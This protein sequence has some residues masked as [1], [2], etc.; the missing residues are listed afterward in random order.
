MI[1]TPGGNLGSALA[2]TPDGKYLATY[3]DSQTVSVSILFYKWSSTFWKLQSS[4]KAVTNVIGSIAHVAISNDGIYAAYT[5]GTNSI[6]VYKRNGNSWGTPVK[7]VASGINRSGYG[8]I[9]S[10]DGSRLFVTCLNTIRG[11]FFGSVA[12]FQR[13]A[14][15]KWVQKQLIHSPN[16]IIG[17]LFGYDSISLSTNA[18]VL[19]VGAPI[20]PFGQTDLIGSF[21]V[22]A[23]NGTSYVQQGKEYQHPSIESDFGNP[24]V[25]SP[26]G[27]SIF[28]GNYNT[29]SVFEY[30]L[31][32][33]TP[34]PT[35][36]F[37]PAPSKPTRAPTQA[38][39]SASC[40]PQ[41]SLSQTSCQQLTNKCSTYGIG[42]KYS[43]SC[44]VN[45]EKLTD[46]GCRPAK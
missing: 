14:L 40:K 24:I 38:P 36:Q 33:K 1:G 9:L 4:L 3:Q 8:V 27:L 25:I 46:G 42:I 29:S 44:I 23:W 18:S 37:T 21:Y 20:W 11:F 30:R 6:L 28:A 7:V 35:L 2:M 26:D 13:N 41:S 10:N 12:Y 32:S 16:N 15:G 34:S 39:A 45:G 22:Y 17:S 43:A 5:V 31:T 19:V